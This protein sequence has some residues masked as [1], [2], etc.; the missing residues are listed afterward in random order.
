MGKFDFEIPQDFIKQ[1]GRLEDVDRVA[2]KML[3]A[4]APILERHVKAEC[5]KHKRTGTMVDS[6]KKTKAKSGKKGY[7]VTV[8]PTGKSTKYIDKDGKLRTRKVP[9]RNMEIMAHIE[10]GTKNQAPKPILTKAVKDATP[11]V[12]RKMQEVFEREV[13]V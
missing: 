4:A 1:L 5:A 11:E 3:D 9:V 12:L 6:V 10:Y 2:P 7:Y 13:K 8:R